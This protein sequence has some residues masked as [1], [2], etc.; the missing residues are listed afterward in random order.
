M[1]ILF[2]PYHI[3]SVFIAHKKE[4]ARKDETTVSMIIAPQRSLLIS[5]ICLT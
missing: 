3:I 4:E 5:F 1:V 2:N